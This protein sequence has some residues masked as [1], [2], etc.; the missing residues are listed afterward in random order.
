VVLRRLVT[1]VVLAR[2]VVMLFVRTRLA[3]PE[4]EQNPDEDQELNQDSMTHGALGSPA[5]ETGQ[6]P[7]R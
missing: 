4:T 2:A 3:E 1:F 6:S 7:I 5:L